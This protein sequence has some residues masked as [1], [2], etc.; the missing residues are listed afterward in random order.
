MNCP[1]MTANWYGSHV[2]AKRAASGVK[3]ML[4]KVRCLTS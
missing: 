3:E 4:R 1:R 2:V